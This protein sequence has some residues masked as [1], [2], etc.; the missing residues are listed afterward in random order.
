MLIFCQDD[1]AETFAEWGS[2][3]ISHTKIRCTAWLF[4]LHYSLFW[5]FQS[6][7]FCF[8]ILMNYSIRGCKILNSSSFEYFLCQT[9]CSLNIFNILTLFLTF[10]TE[11]TLFLISSDDEKYL[12]QF[13]NSIFF[14]RVMFEIKLLL[15]TGR[16]PSLKSKTLISQM[17]LK[18]NQIIQKYQIDVLLKMAKSLQRNSSKLLTS[19]FM[20]ANSYAPHLVFFFFVESQCIGK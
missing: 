15:T 18:N 4:W 11:D 12:G 7:L 1:V 8:R 5:L 13:F 9:I 10:S 17:N 2:T 20:I 6:K 19:Y 14:L 3:F 16:N